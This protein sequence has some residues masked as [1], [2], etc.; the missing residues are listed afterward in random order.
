MSN[1]TTELRVIVEE[2][3]KLQ[4]PEG[5]KSINDL[6]ENAIPE[7]FENYPIFDENYR[8]VLNTK[9]LKHFYFYEIGT[10][11]KGRFLFELNETLNRIMPYYNKLYTL[12]LTEFNPLYSVDTT[13]RHTGQSQDTEHNKSFTTGQDHNISKTESENKSN[14]SNISNSSDKSETNTNDLKSDVSKNTTRKSDTPQGT[15]ANIE[16]NTYLSEADISDGKANSLNQNNAQ[17]KTTN[18]SQSSNNE[19]GNATAT[20]QSN[21]VNNVNKNDNNNKM[22][23]NSYLDHVSGYT[24]YPATLFQ[25]YMDTLINIDDMILKDLSD[26]FMQ[27][28]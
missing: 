26:L 14:S 15:L 22:N 28:Y 1:F 11:T 10:E 23:L 8:N 12:W 3:N 24:E 17:S 13:T 7:I 27:I 20:T 6:I 9:I 16:N 25:K 2:I 5:Y 21:N 19:N 18:F 4:K